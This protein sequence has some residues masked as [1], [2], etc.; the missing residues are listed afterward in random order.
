MAAVLEREILPA[1]IER[2]LI[3]A[4]SCYGMRPGYFIVRKL[5]HPETTKGGIVLPQRYR[6]KAV[7]NLQWIAGKVLAAPSKGRDGK[8][9]PIRPGDTVI[10]NSYNVGKLY[11]QTGEEAVELPVIREMDI[12][13]V[14]REQA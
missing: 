7:G 5:E 12:D 3:K 9:C 4:V 8:D 11:V 6:K 14:V 1:E 2:Q 10:Y 13:A